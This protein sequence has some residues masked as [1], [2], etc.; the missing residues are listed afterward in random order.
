VI[1]R[2]GF[3]QR[4]LKLCQVPSF[5]KLLQLLSCGRLSFCQNI[6]LNV[7][8]GYKNEIENNGYCKRFFIVLIKLV[9]LSVT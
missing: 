7:R 1:I 5:L 8:A 3:W 4:N 2:C 6:S 9:L